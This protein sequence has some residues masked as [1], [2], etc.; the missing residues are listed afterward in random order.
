MVDKMTIGS[1][2]VHKDIRYKIVPEVVEGGCTGCIALNDKTHC[3]KE[4]CGEFNNFMC[5]DLK[6][7]FVEDTSNGAMESLS[8]ILRYLA[9]GGIIEVS[10]K[11]SFNSRFFILDHSLNELVL[12]TFAKKNHIV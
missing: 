6:A 12:Y 4:L 1:T 3:P 7:I 9:D 8:D 2:F 10:S 11:K 5:L